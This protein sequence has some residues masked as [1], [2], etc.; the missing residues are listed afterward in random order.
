MK[1]IT[2]Q[3]LNELI[4]KGEIVLIDVRER[5]EN[6]SCSITGSI[7]IPSSNFDKNKIPQT[8]GKK[9]VFHC[10]AGVRSAMVIQ[11][12]SN[13]NYYNLEG[14]I[15]AWIAAGFKTIG[16]RKKCLPLDRQVQL[17]IG[18]FLILGSLL[19]CFVS[20]KF[21]LV[22]LG[23]GCGLSFAGISGNCFL[24]ML[25]AKAPWNKTNGDKSTCD[26]TTGLC[27]Q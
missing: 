12:L 3:E 16:S 19:T 17:T 21:F 20:T 18:L 25:L 24:A 1:I 7:L 22:S 14:G 10:K 8:N 27:G 6:E 4:K 23:I 26:K 11:K 9:V 13:D 15:D 5:F 2:A